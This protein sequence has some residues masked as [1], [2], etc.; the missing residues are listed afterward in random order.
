MRIGQAKRTGK[1][2]DRETFHCDRGSFVAV[3]RGA[4]AA[5]GET[6]TRA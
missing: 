2:G 6:A 5:T 4:I 1:V 3:P